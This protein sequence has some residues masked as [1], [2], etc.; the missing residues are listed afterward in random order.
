MTSIRKELIVDNYVKA[1]EQL[2]KCSGM[3][4]FVQEDRI[5]RCESNIPLGPI[6]SVLTYQRSETKDPIDEVKELEDAYAAEGRKL[7][8][9]TYSHQ[10]DEL[11]EQALQV[12]EF[13]SI[14]EMTGFGLLLE[15]WTSDLFIHGLDVRPV[16]SEAELESYRA[17]ALAGFEIPDNMADI[18]SKIFVDGP[19]QDKAFHHYVA[20]MEGE[21]VTT[22]T[23]FEADGVVGIYNVATPAGHRRRGYA[24]TAIAHVLRELQ[25]RG[26]KEAAIIATPM[27]M[28]VYPSV[29][30]KEEFKIRVYSK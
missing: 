21:P 27:A 28:S 8:W 3:F 13:Q 14:E 25:H 19:T 1:Y 26:V 30:F 2:S 23:T 11:V 18:F 16:Q 10:P 24:R 15:D 6:N 20:Y 4:T 17:L 12:N 7:I 22:L 5:Q 9:L 29:G